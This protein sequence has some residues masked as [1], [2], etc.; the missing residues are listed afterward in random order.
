[1]LK[2]TEGL[3]EVCEYCGSKLGWD[4]V[5]LVCSNPNCAHKYNQRLKAWIMNLAPVDG[6]GWKTVEKVISSPFYTIGGGSKYAVNIENITNGNL[7]PI[8]G[9]TFGHGEEG[10]WN[11]MLD[12]LQNGKFTISQFL[13]ALN[14]PGLGKKGAKALEDCEDIIY[15]FDSIAEGK[16][17]TD[18]V[19]TMSKLLQDSNVVDAIYNEYY[20][21]FKLCYNLIKDR[22]I[23]IDIPDYKSE[24]IGDVVI[25]GKLSVKRADFEQ[26]LKDNGFKLSSSVSKNTM[27]LITD[28]PN[29]GT[30]KNKK[31]DELGITKITEADFRA[32]YNF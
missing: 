17:D 26:L 25:T 4:S 24:Y 21:H 6:M 13:L 9:V 12:I 23:L 10:G 27:Y 11:A 22:L 20:D 29:S 2:T 16:Y 30:G 15:M 3:P 31:A 7:Q 1:M 18:I 5:H 14:I 32:K 19:N 28:D 8:P